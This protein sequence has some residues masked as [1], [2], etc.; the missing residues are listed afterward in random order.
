MFSLTCGAL[1]PS[2]LLL[3]ELLSY[4]YNGLSD[5]YLLRV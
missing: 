2:R 1:Y 5:V 4:G 3:C